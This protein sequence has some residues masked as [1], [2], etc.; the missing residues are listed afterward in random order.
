ML[1]KPLVGYEESYAISDTGLIKRIESRGLDG[2]LLC[3]KF[4]H[5]GCYPNGYWFVCLAKNGT[6]KQEMTH[7]LVAKTFIP[8]PNN[9]PVVNHIDGNKNNNHV[10]N[11]EWC[12]HS[13]NRQ[14]AYDTGLSP[15]RGVPRKVTIKCGEHITTFDTMKDCANFFGF[16]KC[17]LT[18]QIRKHGCI[19]N[20]GEYE[21]EVHGKGVV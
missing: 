3:E 21:I 16:K 6:Y 14:H 12:S 18:N 20:Y 10:T 2:R 8:N 11:L 5:G 4:I 15:Q 1:W 9:L 7:R 13:Q 17:W 19:F